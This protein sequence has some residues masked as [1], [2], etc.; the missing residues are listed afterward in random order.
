MSR[1]ESVDD[2]MSILQAD[3]ASR[4]EYIPY[5]QMRARAWD[6]ARQEEE[7]EMLKYEYLRQEEE[8]TR[9][10]CLTSDDEPQEDIKG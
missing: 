6:L 2:W 3:A 9:R 4:K 8:V 7:L 1:T 5:R 10:I